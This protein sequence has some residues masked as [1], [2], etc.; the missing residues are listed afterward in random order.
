MR[1]TLS[2][3]LG[4]ALSSLGLAGCGTFSIPSIAV[5]GTT[6]VIPVPDAFG[7]GFG[8]AL[9]QDLPFGV[10]DP[11]SRVIDPTLNPLLEDFQRGELL[12]ALRTGPTLGS[13]L[14]TYLPVRYITRVHA[15]EATGAALPPAAGEGYINVGTP[16]Q[17]GQIVAF[18]DV[19]QATP[20]G[21]WYVFIERW[22]RKPGA[23]SQFEQLAPKTIN[24][25]TTTLPWHAWAGWGGWGGYV[26]SPD[27]PLKIR[28]VASTYGTLFHDTAWGFDRW[29]FDGTYAFLNYT[30][31][32]KHLVPNSKLRI[33]IVN[34]STGEF[35]AAWE[36]TLA[37]P[38]GKL[39]ITGAALGRLH[40]S[41]GLVGVNTAGSPSGCGGSGTTRISLIDPDR[42]TQWVDVVYRLRDYANCGRAIPS[43]FTAVENSLKAYNAD[44]NLITAI[45][46]PDPE[47]SF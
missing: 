41:G 10:V 1:K 37:Y 3:F 40:L 16:V 7:A 11:A 36:I 6:I 22:R 27:A 28:V 35:P 26:S 29:S 20:P 19:P 21:T 45:A 18:V 4:L 24:F 32:L 38:A 33:R 46:Y 31:D 5:Q 9:N 12:F 44:G 43:D 23:S 14:I 34:P 17:T 2:G 15:D 8:R 42:Y 39:E 13:S 47:Y 25:S 30:E